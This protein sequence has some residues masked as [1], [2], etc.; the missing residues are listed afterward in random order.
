[1]RS[2]RTLVPLF[3]SFFLAGSLAAQTA[4][5]SPL[6]ERTVVSLLI[7]GVIPQTLVVDIQSRGLNFDPN[8][9]TA[10]LQAMGIDQSVLAALSTARIFHDD[11]VVRHADDDVV[12]NH[13]LSA[14]NDVLHKRFDKAGEELTRATQ[15]LD[16]HPEV[17]FAVGDLFRRQQYFSQAKTVYAELLKIA[18]RFPHAHTKLA[19][20]LYKL[21][22]YEGTINESKAA[23]QL[24]PADAEAHRNLA[25]GLSSLERY[26]AAVDEYHQALKLVPT[27]ARVYYALGNDYAK[28][29]DYDSAVTAYRKALLLD[30]GDA[31]C[32]Y[33]LG[34]ILKYK[35]ENGDALK[36]YR[37]AIRL[38][39][40]F[41][42]PRMNLAMLLSKTGSTR[43]GVEQFRALIRLYPDSEYCHRCFGELLYK[44]HQIDAALDEFT[45]A[46][47]IDPADD[48]PHYWKGLVFLQ[49]KRQDEAFKEFLV[50]EKLDP[51]NAETHR[52]LGLIYEAQSHHTDAISEF[53]QG[54]A[55]TPTDARMHTLLASEY[56][57]AGRNLDAIAE[58]RQAIALGASDDAILRLASLLEK[59]GQS[60]EA[61]QLY[62]QAYEK[63]PND[64]TRQEYLEAQSRISGIKEPTPANS[65]VTSATT[66]L[67]VTPTGSQGSSDEDGDN[68]GLLVELQEKSKERDDA[69]AHQRWKE[70]EA[71]G[72][73]AIAAAEKLEPQDESLVEAIKRL[74][75]AYMMRGRYADA[76][77]EYLHA[78]KVSTDLF[79]AN[80]RSAAWDMHELAQ[81]YL[82]QRNYSQAIEYANRSLAL[83]DRLQGPGGRFG[84]LDLIGEAYQG[85]GELSKAR[86]AYKQMLADMESVHGPA[87]F[88]ITTALE[89]MG[90][91]SLE[92][93]DYDAANG[94]FT[95]ML[96]LDEKQY[97]PNSPVLSGTLDH[98]ARTAREMGQTDIALAYDHRREMLK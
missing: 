68:H 49:T 97:G 21:D 47:T 69:I 2:P 23:L 76:E 18:D 11:T 39:P 40:D 19:Y 33:N 91:I 59:K 36:E 81:L 87:N 17:A 48:Q 34:N 42:A 29:K 54:V 14:E 24:M 5:A 45:K 35:G 89:R 27:Y 61:L 74:A 94:Y 78:L 71:A 95:R 26:D 12:L 64:V 80:S 41:F 84:D 56:E 8:H 7:G 57:L 73:A 20:V 25:I 92:L 75:G 10:S 79:G 67:N 28:R 46:Q 51:A 13:L 30:P 66:G 77:R 31:E 58:Y 86:D 6:D 3:I 53:K 44:D 82:R 88:I 16:D 63:H 50:A 90:M 98:L 22:D 55:L 43:E 38:D 37:E 60:A 1:M 62:R 65:S 52:Q 4:A 9:L 93:K 85:M 70:A 15:N 83:E 96:R 72:L 32:H